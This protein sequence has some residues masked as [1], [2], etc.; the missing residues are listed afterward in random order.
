MSPEPPFMWTGVGSL[1]NVKKFILGFILIVVVVAGYLAFKFFFISEDTAPG[2]HTTV[3]CNTE[4]NVCEQF[5]PASNSGLLKITI[6]TRTG[7]PAKDLEVDLGTKPGATEF[8]MKYTDKNGI[9]EFD[10][11][12]SG[13]YVVYFNGTTFIKDYGSPTTTERVEINKNQTTEKTIVLNK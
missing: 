5:T 9:A 1:N 3:L 8:Y 10:G 6:L 12:P 11:I 2:Q 7:M 13:S 4:R